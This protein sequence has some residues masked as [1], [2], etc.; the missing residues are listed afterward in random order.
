MAVDKINDS[1][2]VNGVQYFFPTF[3]PTL[4]EISYFNM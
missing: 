3:F 4:C 1:T 2:V